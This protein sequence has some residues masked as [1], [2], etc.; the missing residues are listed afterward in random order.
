VSLSAG[1]YWL[2]YHPSS[3]G[4]E[5]KTAFF[6]NNDSARSV[7][8]SFGALPSAFPTTGVSVG[9][10]HEWSFYATL[11]SGTSMLNT[12]SQ[13]ASSGSVAD[14]LEGMKQSLLNALGYLQQ[15]AH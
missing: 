3:G 12:Q 2:A 4:L 5:F 8:Q 10:G 9:G 15:L 14:Q 6:V 1:G 11:T 13:F 7:S